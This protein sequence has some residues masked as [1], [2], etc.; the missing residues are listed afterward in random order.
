M[1]GMIAKAIALPFMKDFPDRV[2]SAHPDYPRLS[3]KLQ[4]GVIIPTW[5]F[6]SAA[7]PPSSPS[8][9]SSSAP[10]SAPAPAPVAARS[11][12]THRTPTPHL[13]P[14]PCAADPP[15]ALAPPQA[16]PPRPALSP[17]ANP[18]LP[19]PSH[20]ADLPRLAPSPRATAPPGHPLSPTDA[21]ANQPF[22]LGP[23]RRMPESNPAAVQLAQPPIAAKTY[24]APASTSM[25]STSTSSR[26]G[27]PARPLREAAIPGNVN[28][29]NVTTRRKNRVQ[30]SA[31]PAPDQSVDANNDSDNSLY[32]AR[33]AEQ[34]T[35]C[36][37]T[38]LCLSRLSQHLLH[39]L[40]PFVEP[41]P[42]SS[43]CS[44]SDDDVPP[45]PLART[46]VT[47]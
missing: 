30:P 25:S 19:T 8:S 9:S 37:Y 26:S 38:C 3:L 40:A 15:R 17:R 1:E 13:T 41:S 45:V 27:R 42:P 24:R 23:F 39:L 43:I 4:P 2:K 6:E 33:S 32:V 31:S 46:H 29:T 44:V 7:S 34:P 22:P 10:I 28:A 18:L 20:R 47:V 36:A 21:P 11:P 35:T 5:T 16:N 12:N 14:A